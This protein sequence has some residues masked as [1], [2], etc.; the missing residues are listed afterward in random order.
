MHR[1]KA[2]LKALLY[3]LALW[4]ARPSRKELVSG[5]IAHTARLELIKGETRKLPPVD[6]T[7]GP[8]V[9]TGNSCPLIEY[10]AFDES[11]MEFIRV[12]VALNL[13]DR[14]MFTAKI[15]D[16]KREDCPT[17]AVKPEYESPFFIWA[18]HVY[19]YFPLMAEE[20]R[21]LVHLA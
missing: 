13:P 8:F 19:R 2:K 5:L 12:S 17:V 10:T 9:I 20:K 11:L 1:L 18:H 7:F 6:G 3:R 21:N 4:L 16:D 15:Q 14:I